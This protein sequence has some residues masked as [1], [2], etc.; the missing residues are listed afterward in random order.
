MP[1]YLL[2]C[3]LLSATVAAPD[4]VEV[5]SVEGRRVLNVAGRPAAELNQPWLATGDWK[6]VRQFPV[7][8]TP[9]RTAIDGGERLVRSETGPHGRWTETITVTAQQVTIRYEFDLAADVG[10]ANLQ[11]W[12]RLD[13]AVY[14][15][16]MAEGAGQRPVALRSV[17]G[18]TVKPLQRIS[19]VWPERELTVRC[20]AA[21]GDWQFSDQ[22]QAAWARC[23][24]L[25][26]NR[27]L[28]AGAAQ[29][30]WF[31]VSVSG[32]ALSEVVV[33]LAAGPATNVR[34]LAVPVGAP[35][36]A[37]ERKLAA[38][39]LLH[40]ATVP[41]QRDQVVGEVTVGYADGQ[42][43]VIPLRWE[44]AVTAPDDDPREL[45]DGA[46]VK[47]GDGPAW[48]TS[49]RNP[50]P[51]V[52]VRSLTARTAAG[53][54]RLVGAA[55]LAADA[56]ERQLAATFARLRGTPLAE[57]S[58]IS[59]DGTWR[60]TPAGQTERDL[61]VP[62][63]WERIKGLGGVAQMTY[64]RRFDVPEAF[65]GQRVVLRFDAVGDG[66]EVWVNGQHAGGFVN[67][68]LPSEVDITGLVAVPSRDNQLEVRVKDDSH[69]SVPRPSSD[70]RDRRTW[71]PRGIGAHNRKGLI[72]S[73]SLRGRPA[74]QV[75]DV[76]VQT[77][78]RRKRLTVVY[79][80]FN[81]RPDTVRAELTGTVRP[82]AGGAVVLR[83]PPQT[84]E[85]PGYVTT[86]VTVTAAVPDSVTLW[87]PDHPALYTLRSLLS[88]AGGQRLQRVDTRFG[89]REVWFEGVHFRLNGIRC[90]LRGES[91]SYA[92]PTLFAT[93]EAATE[94]VQRCQRANFNVLRFHAVPA[95]PH[96]LDV[97]DELGMLVIDESG[98]YASWHMLMPD[99]PEF[100][101]RCREHLT[102]WV[103]RDRNHP[104]VVLWSAEN[105]GLNVNHLSA[106]QLAEYRRV[107]DAHDGTRPV[108]FDGD[109]TAH[110]ASPASVKHYVSRV[111]D[112]GEAGGHS[113]GY[114]HD[115]R[116]D[117]YWATAHQQK[118]PLG[119]GEFLFPYEPGQRDQER[120]VI[121]QM[122]LQTRGYR[123]ANWFDIRPYNPSYCGF[124]K[125]EGVR[126]GYEEVYDVIAKSFAAVAVYDKDYDA[127]GPFP[128]PPK[129]QV[130]RPVK[131]TLIVYN[132]EFAD[133]QVTVTW[134][135][136][137]AG[138]HLAGEQK[139]LAI[140]LGDHTLFEVTF[141][142]NAPGELVLE[143]SSSKGGRERFRDRRRFEARP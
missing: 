55:G 16:V 21:D 131:R 109:G 38:L 40:T 93:R 64:R 56:T 89:F 65:A 133:E 134:Q 104:A 113:S 82:A 27:P 117:I 115:L 130:G 62:A 80:L 17:A 124:L 54:W 125:P 10:A 61:P 78:V 92:D 7:G 51:E 8:Q 52:P 1:L 138:Q 29:R 91:P 118:L 107:I 121:Y 139:A 102:R 120:E 119:C 127:L 66:A 2:L 114:G 3:P 99:H 98:I 129:L 37:A 26:Y 43:A 42:T 9:Q 44:Q 48:L 50:R 90:N 58:V 46:L 34:G 47:L 20:A 136:T 53:G 22:R 112:L 140:P 13:P 69:Y 95:P 6:S 5:T 96:V 111:E 49:W 108:I 137:L 45:P 101:D 103:R 72:Q 14:E 81:S 41:A 128:Q 60:A 141:T 31:E 132:D 18:L 23:Y 87:Q 57:E 105:E 4:G 143:L 39:L 123:L 67:P 70:W 83:L 36:L 97:C 35:Q 68:A 28:K 126:P 25:E 122:G 77:S 86:T 30:G 75:A 142:P 116:S 110:G 79:E 73:V 74:V 24:R 59:L 135:A 106:A 76:R 33:P 32:R 12:W 63:M 88:A 71:I 84:V 19:F 100:M 85:L 15:G 11:W 94:M